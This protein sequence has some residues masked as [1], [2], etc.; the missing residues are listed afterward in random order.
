VRVLCLT[1]WFPDA[2]GGREGNYIYDSVMALREQG[3]DVKVLLSRAWK[4]WLHNEPDYPLFAPELGL[5]TVYYPGIPRDY[6]KRISNRMLFY[7]LY[8]KVKAYARKHQVQLIHA[9]TEALAEVAFAAARSLGIKV[10]VT[11]HGINTWHR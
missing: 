5:H 2:P 6:M 9:H 8:R 11:I 10:V 4:P 7:T 3:V 1:P